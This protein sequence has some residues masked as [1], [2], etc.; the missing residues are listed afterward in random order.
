MDLLCSDLTSLKDLD[1]GRASAAFPMAMSPVTL[2]NYN[3]PTAHCEGQREIG[4]LKPAG[5]TDWY[6]ILA[7]RLAAHCRSLRLGAES[8]CHLL[9]GGIAKLGVASLSG[10]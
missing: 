1:R 10:C 4:W 9:D 2:K 8:L 3:Q 5:E 7:C 6:I